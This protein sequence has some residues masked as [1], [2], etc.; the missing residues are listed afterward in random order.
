MDGERRKWERERGG[1]RVTRCDRVAPLLSPPLPFSP[2]A[3]SASR[4][5]TFLLLA[6]A[7]IAAGVGAVE[8]IAQRRQRV[9]A[10]TADQREDLF[11]NEQLFCDLKL[12]DQKR[13]RDLYAAI[14]ND[15]QRDKL[16]RVMNRYC[17]WFEDQPPFRR[18]QLQRLKPQERVAE[19]KKLLAKQKGAAGIHLDDKNRQAVARWMDRYTSDHEARFIEMISQAGRGMGKPPPMPPF[20]HSGPG[21]EGEGVAAALA[22]LP[23][24]EQHRVVRAILYR[25]WQSGNPA[26]QP[27]ISEQEMAR[28]RASLTPDLRR[29]LESRQPPEQAQIIASWLRETA[30]SELDERLADFF[31]NTLN[32]EERDRL[33]SLPGDEMYD[34]LGKMYNAHLRQPR[35]GEPHHNELPH[36]GE[37]RHGRHPGGPRAS[38]GRRWQEML[39]ERGGHAETGAKSSKAPQPAKS[40]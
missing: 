34:R 35:P 5:I 2:L 1:E 32:D 29:R 27:P 3:R 37:W 11:H 33:M 10:M 28:L 18:G 39:E 16:L 8:T 12:E 9:E 7:A 36:K 20:P 19:I 14:E 40:T 30:S 13:V 26:F 21:W 23:P 4:C 17:K 6:A 38:E 22:K 15:P 31:E 24:Q 25:R